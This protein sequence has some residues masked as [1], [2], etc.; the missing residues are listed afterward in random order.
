ME[1]KLLGYKVRTKTDLWAMDRK[2]GNFW[3][4]KIWNVTDFGNKA[5]NHLCCIPLLSITL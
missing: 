5:Q 4:N 2:R 1:W 3:F